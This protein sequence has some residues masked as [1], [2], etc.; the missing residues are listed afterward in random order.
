MQK[1]KEKNTKELDS[2]LA[3]SN[4]IHNEVDNIGELSNLRIVPNLRIYGVCSKKRKDKFSTR[5]PNIKY[6]SWC[7]E[8][9]FKT[10]DAPFV[11]IN[12]LEIYKQYDYNLEQSLVTADTIDDILNL[13][14]KEVFLTPIP[15]TD[16]NFICSVNFKLIGNLSSELYEEDIVLNES[17]TIDELTDVK[18][19][20][21]DKIKYNFSDDEIKIREYPSNRLFD[22]EPNRLERIQEEIFTFAAGMIFLSAFLVV[23]NMSIVMAC[24]SISTISFIIVGILSLLDSKWYYARERFERDDTVELDYHINTVKKDYNITER[25][26]K[27][28]V[29]LDNDFIKADDKNI[30]WEISGDNFSVYNKDATEFFIDMGFE[31]VQEE[32]EAYK[33]PNSNSYDLDSSIESHCG[34]WLLVPKSRI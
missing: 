27:I 32:F 7:D 6:T 13:D 29:Y 2:R 28:D 22:I 4:D 10:K 34:N 16:R 1:Q 26:S 17:E 31:N 21:M 9:D 11:D 19:N 24:L 25:A 30:K 20:D 5:D 33:V 8:S 18:F 12:D 3:E 23:T 14:D 15:E